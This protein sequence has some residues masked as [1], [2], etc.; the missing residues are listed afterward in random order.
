[1]ASIDQLNTEL[2]DLV[3]KVAG[4]PLEEIRPDK[5]LT[6]DL[7]IDSLSVAEIIIAVEEVFGVRI[8]DAD[9]SDISTIHEVAAYIHKAQAKQ[10]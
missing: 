8:P 2:S 6:S 10:L 1:M 5:S 7:D 9:M 3:N 4:V